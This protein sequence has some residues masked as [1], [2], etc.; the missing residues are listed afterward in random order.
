MSWTL[1]EGPR[2]GWWREAG[3]PCTVGPQGLTPAWAVCPHTLR[4]EV[5]QGMEG[6]GEEPTGT[7]MGLSTLITS[8]QRTE[9]PRWCTLTPWTLHSG[10]KAHMRQK[11]VLWGSQGLVGRGAPR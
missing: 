11:N 10:Q 5:A 9:G 4:F 2:L 6:T 8:F 1:R 3:C 7:A